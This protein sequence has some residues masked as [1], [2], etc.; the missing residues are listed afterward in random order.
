MTCAAAAEGGHV[1]VLQFLNAQEPPCPWDGK[2]VAGRCSVGLIDI[3]TIKSVGL[4]CICTIKSVGLIGI[5]KT[6]AG[7]V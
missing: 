2:T 5:Y 7:K 1:D 6:V 4:I 3:F